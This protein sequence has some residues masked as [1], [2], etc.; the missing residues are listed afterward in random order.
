V[1]ATPGP[2]RDAAVTNIIKATGLEQPVD[3]ELLVATIYLAVCE[4]AEESDFAKLDS[5]T[6]RERFTQFRKGIEHCIKQMRHPW[7]KEMAA[8]HR[9]PDLLRRLHVWEHWYGRRGAEEARRSKG[10][11][12]PSRIERLIGL[13]LPLAYRCCFRLPDT[14][15][16]K[17]GEPSGPVIRFI[18][19]VLAEL[20]LTDLTLS[21]ETIGTAMHQLKRLRDA[22]AKHGVYT[23]AHWEKKFTKRLLDKIRDLVGQK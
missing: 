4:Y 8:S 1:F 11:R 22:Y 18:A 13:W 5:K 23:P 21:N 3:R 10:Q 17:D 6:S 2:A 9:L 19:A 14:W 7:L 15:S 12:Q 16:R 20:N